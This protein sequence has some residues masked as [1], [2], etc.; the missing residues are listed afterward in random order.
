MEIGAEM[1]NLEKTDRRIRRTKKAIKEALIE[2]LKKKNVENVTIKELA[3]KAD[4]TRAT[5][6]QYY[7]DPVDT[8]EQ[9]QKEI[10]ADLQKIVE[11]TEGGDAAGFFAL[12]FQYFYEDKT[13]ADILSFSMQNQTGY[14]K[15]GQ[16]IHNKYMLR[17]KDK[18]I[19]KSLKQYEYYRCYIVFGC[20]AVVENWVRYGMKET[21]EEMTEIAVSLLPKQKMYLK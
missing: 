18:Y 2:V 7:R 10:C 12:L 1:E 11:K 14:E 6:Y 20:I 8:L 17:W 4:I 13:K 21:P 15:L 19:D 16:Y 9:L 5:F 3:D